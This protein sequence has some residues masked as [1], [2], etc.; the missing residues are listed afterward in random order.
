MAFLIFVYYKL[1]V[2]VIHS[3]FWYFTIVAFIFDFEA[4]GVEMKLSEF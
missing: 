3:H 2:I 1:F 4:E